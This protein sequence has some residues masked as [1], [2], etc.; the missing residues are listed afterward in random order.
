MSLHRQVVRSS[1]ALLGLTL[2]F[3]V[4]VF[5]SYA[6]EIFNPKPAPAFKAK[7][8]KGSDLDIR[9][10]KGHLILLEFWRRECS[11]CMLTMEK[12]V[13]LR[14][15]IP[16]EQLTM[17]GINCDE[18]K[19]VPINFLRRKPANWPQIHAGSQETDLTHLYE[20]E[21]LPAFCVIDPDGNLI[22]RAER[23]NVDDLVEILAPRLPNVSEH[24]TE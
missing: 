9:K 5:H 2:V 6:G 15:D 13:Q 7:T 23:G 1:S 22:Y 16:E 24:G 19:T 18:D 20:V 8:L 17:I 10:L 14:K 21:D 11:D 3:A 12:L 4:G